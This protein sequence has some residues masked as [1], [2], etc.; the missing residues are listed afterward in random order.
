MTVYLCLRHYIDRKMNIL[1]LKRIRSSHLENL[2]FT[3]INSRSFTVEHFTHINVKSS[4]SLFLTLNLLC[5]TTF[6]FRV[7]HLVFVAADNRLPSDIE[8][9]DS[10]WILQT[11]KKRIFMD[12][13]TSSSKFYSSFTLTY[14]TIYVH[15]IFAILYMWP[16][17][18]SF[19]R[20]ILEDMPTVWL[21]FS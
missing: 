14:T 4:T 20:N 7:H 16:N 9:I 12:K 3:D 13:K 10:L 1:I 19:R 18:F 6:R 15:M 17:K 21:F 8:Q 5:T 2:I 11:F